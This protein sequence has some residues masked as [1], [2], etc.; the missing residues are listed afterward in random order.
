MSFIIS[1]AGIVFAFFMLY[2][3]FLVVDE[4]DKKS[5]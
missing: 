4:G 2:A 5:D 3:T 1:F